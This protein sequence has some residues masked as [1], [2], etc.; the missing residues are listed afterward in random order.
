MFQNLKAEWHWRERKWLLSGGRLI[1]SPAWN[2][3]EYVKYKNKDGKIG[4]QPKEELFRDGLMSPN[5]VDAAVLTMVISDS[6]IR[7]NSVMKNGGLPF[8]D[9]M[10]SIY[11]QG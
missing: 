11:D 5:C 3:F 2:E 6:V 10:Q 4:I 9:K 8:Y 1:Q 7:N